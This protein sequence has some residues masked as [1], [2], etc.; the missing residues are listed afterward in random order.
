MNFEKGKI[1]IALMLPILML[2]LMV[3]KNIKDWLVALNNRLSSKC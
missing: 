1:L 3:E 2:F